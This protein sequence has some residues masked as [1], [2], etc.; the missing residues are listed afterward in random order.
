MWIYLAESCTDSTSSRESAGSRKRCADTFVLSPIVKT[1]DTLPPSFYRAWLEAN[2]PG[3]RSGMTCERSKV[4]C[5]MNQRSFTAVFP[6]KTFQLPDAEKAWTES[7]AVFSSR[8]LGLSAKF[9]PDSSSW[10]TCQLSLLGGGCE[11]LPNLSP[12]G[13]TLDGAFYPLRMWARIT[14]ENGGGFW[15]TPDTVTGGTS[16]H[17]KKGIDIR[18]TGS[19]IQIRLQDAVINQRFWPTPR[20]EHGQGCPNLATAA[21]GQLNPTWVEWIM[22]YP[23]GWTVLE[24]WA[25]RWFR[26]KREKPLKD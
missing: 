3:L 17:L 9:D 18:P 7:V 14:S 16:G 24:D 11:L 15:P 26:P 23:C 5:S 22:G 6:A 21:G 1:T 2:S 10:K 4:R 20:A 13:M 8:S 19:K 25:M 12:Y